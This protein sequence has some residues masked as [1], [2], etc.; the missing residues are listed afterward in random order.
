LPPGRAWLATRPLLTGLFA[1]AKTIGTSD[2]TR[3]AARALKAPAV[4]MTSPLNRANS[5]AISEKLS[6]RLSAQR[7]SSHFEVDR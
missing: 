1:S 6:G 2:V 4:K 5:A 7:Y 3:L